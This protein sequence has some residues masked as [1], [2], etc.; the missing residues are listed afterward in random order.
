MQ[1]SKRSIPFLH[2]SSTNAGNVAERIS[3]LLRPIH[4]YSV[5][6]P[7]SLKAD[8]CKE[9]APQE[10]FVFETP[11]NVALIRISFATTWYLNSFQHL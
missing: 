6:E 2:T 10:I 11:K 5:I 3:Q 9:M 8:I 7:R 4:A 1:I